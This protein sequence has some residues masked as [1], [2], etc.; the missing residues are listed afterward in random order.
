[1]KRLDIAGRVPVNC[2]HCQAATQGDVQLPWAL[3][4]LHRSGYREERGTRASTT[5]RLTQRSLVHKQH[6]DGLPLWLTASGILPAE[7]LAPA[8]LRPA[9]H[10]GLSGAQVHAWHLGLAALLM[11]SNSDLAEHQRWSLALS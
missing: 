11:L 9:A 2:Y 1:M 7:C 10:T 8:M 3:S 4:R 5:E 6:H